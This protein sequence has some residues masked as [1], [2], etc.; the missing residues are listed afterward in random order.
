M[1]PQGGADLKPAW[2][3]IGV[4]KALSADIYVL[5]TSS[6]SAIKLALQLTAGGSGSV[7]HGPVS[8]SFIQNEEGNL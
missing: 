3:L 6:A 5:V 8:V 1:T 7:A 4:L 2:V